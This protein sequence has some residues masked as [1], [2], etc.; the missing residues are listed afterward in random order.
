MALPGV[1]PIRRWCQLVHQL[2]LMQELHGQQ[3]PRFWRLLPDVDF[4]ACRNLADAKIEIPLPFDFHLA[5]G[6]RT[7]IVDGTVLR[8]AA[9]N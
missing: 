9:M 2:D 5:P 4:R 3:L 6:D 7:P 8:V 1:C